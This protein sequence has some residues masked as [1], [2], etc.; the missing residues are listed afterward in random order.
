[1]KPLPVLC[2]LLLILATAC[3][4][5]SPDSTPEDPVPPGGEA[6]AV[7]TAEEL[8]TVPPE[9]TP[10]AAAPAQTAPRPGARAPARTPAAGGPP[11]TQPD[12]QPDPVSPVAEPLALRVG[13]ELAVTTAAE[14]TS[15]TNKVGETFTTTVVADVDDDAGRTVVP[16]GAALTLRILEIKPAENTGGQGTLVLQ[17]VS[18]RIDGE[19]YPLKADVTALQTELKGRGVTGGDAAKVGAGAAAGAV[20]GQILG[21]K[22]SSTVIGGVVGAAVGTAVAVKTADRD[23]VVPAGSRIALRLSSEFTREAP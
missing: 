3:A 16:A 5:S 7:V 17:T 2:A 9:D 15:R 6:A 8:G 12:P 10:A 13:S 20:L 4:G 14:I 23:I 1:M 22:T 18:V 21:K 11:A 19:D